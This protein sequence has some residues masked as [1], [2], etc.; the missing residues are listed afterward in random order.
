MTLTFSD[1]IG[2]IGLAV[3]LVGV[4][5]GIIGCFNLSKAN[6]LK[7]KKISNSTINQTETMI[8]NNGLDNYAVIKL[9]RDTTKEEL[10]EITETLSATTLDLQ[11]LREEVDAMPRFSHG[12]EPPTGQ[13]RE[14]DI[15]FQI[16]N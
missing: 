10:Q 5:V 15:Y 14:G 12:V 6:K 7:T 4:V 8:V 16:I 1:W 11:K 3:G 13:A 9:A 2:I